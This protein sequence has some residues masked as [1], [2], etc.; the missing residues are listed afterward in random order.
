[1]SISEPS[2]FGKLTERI[3]RLDSHIHV[4]FL[5]LLSKY[6]NENILLREAKLGKRNHAASWG[7]HPEF[8]M[9]ATRKGTDLIACRYAC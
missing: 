3:R 7:D 2:G 6:L 8:H 1:M 9:H 5:P 4:N